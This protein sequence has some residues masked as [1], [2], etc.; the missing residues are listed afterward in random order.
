MSDRSKTSS[1]CFYLLAE[2][3][4]PRQTCLQQARLRRAWFLPV[5]VDTIWFQVALYLSYHVDVVY[6]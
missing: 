1:G 2:R 5:D 3:Y 4:A 6:I